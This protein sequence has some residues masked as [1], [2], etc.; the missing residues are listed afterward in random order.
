MKFRITAMAARFVV[1]L[2]RLSFVTACMV[3][4]YD[5][6]GICSR[7]FCVGAACQARLQC[8]LTA[9]LTRNGGLTHAWILAERA[10]LATCS[11]SAAGL[12]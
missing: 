5:Q 3:L 2:L 10:Q 6:S 11:Y 8:C 1:S 12:A 4:M 7:L 9:Q